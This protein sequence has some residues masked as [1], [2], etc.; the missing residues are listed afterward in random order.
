MKMSD[1]QKQVYQIITT[2]ERCIEDLYWK[3]GDEVIGDFF[4]DIAEI[5]SNYK[6]RCASYRGKSK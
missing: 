5:K 3:T 6:K 1:E 4:S 2:A